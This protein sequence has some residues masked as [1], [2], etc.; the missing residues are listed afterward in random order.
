MA[1][2]VASLPAG[3]SCCAHFRR[4]YSAAVNT[5]KSTTLCQRTKVKGIIRLPISPDSLRTTME[6]ATEL[7]CLERRRATRA[8]SR[9]GCN[10]SFRIV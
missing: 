10:Q 2:T 6:I 1:R 9:C 7:H 8:A 5:K 3:R 4:M